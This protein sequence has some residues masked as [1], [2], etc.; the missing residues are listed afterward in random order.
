[1]IIEKLL[2]FSQSFLEAIWALTII[3]VV[4]SNAK[5]KFIRIMIFA[6]VLATISLILDFDHLPFHSYLTIAIGISLFLVL[7]RP[8]KASVWN[9]SI[10]ITISFLSMAAVQLLITGLAFLFGINLIENKIA[11]LLILVV[12]ILLTKR[13]ESI[14]S[15]YIFLEKYYIPYRTTI[16]FAVITLIFLIANLINIILNHVELFLTGGSAQINLLIAG[17]IFVTICLFVSLYRGKK[18]T[19]KSSSLM[20]YSEQLQSLINEQSANE[21]DLRHHL[22]IIANQCTCPECSSR[23]TELETYIN[24]VIGN[25][26]TSGV[27]SIIKDDVIIS[28]LLSQKK[29]YAK[30][31]RIDFNVSIMSLISAYYKSLTCNELVDILNNIINNAFEEVEKLD[32][33]NRFVQ[34]NLA[35]YYIEII[36][37]VSV[38]LVRDGEERA[39]HFGEQG[40][41]TKGAGRGF[42][43]S[44]VLNIANRNGIIIDKKLENELYV[45]RLIF[46][47]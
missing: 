41:S 9:Y 18:A 20:L 10:D 26:D 39:Q 15:V 31:K 4:N 6:T 38:S 25:R 12:L 19:E 34:V 16:L 43:L 37:K 3:S 1:M 32:I 36:N 28:A 14:I 7:K 46:K 8:P 45:F 11:V 33:E 13:L 40:F 24:S 42:G 29:E 21:H 44:N 22:Q 47:K 5:L 30:E 27:S 2:I 23:N 17:Y 35:E